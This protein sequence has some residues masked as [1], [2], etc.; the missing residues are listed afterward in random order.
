MV[1]GA[2][3]QRRSRDV[4]EPC[5]A[6]PQAAAFV[7]GLGNVEECTGRHSGVEVRR[8][9]LAAR[10]A[11]PAAAG[12]V[13]VVSRPVEIIV[14]PADQGLNHTRI[15]SVRRSGRAACGY[16]EESRGGN[17]NGHQLRRLPLPL[18]LYATAL[19]HS[20]SAA[21]LPSGGPRM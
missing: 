15:G 1:A 18:I 6:R 21:F 17:V 7:S 20:R 9:R 12:V 14:P 13:D 16:S 19:S 4:E 11:G 10:A 5:T 3:M 2:A 8:R